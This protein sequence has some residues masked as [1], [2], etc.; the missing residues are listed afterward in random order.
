MP[1]P[2]NIVQMDPE[3]IAR[4]NEFVGKWAN[5]WLGDRYYHQAEIVQFVPAGKLPLKKYWVKVADKD[6]IVPIPRDYD[7]LLVRLKDG[8]YCY[9]PLDAHRE[10]GVI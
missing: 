10:V 7:S 3:A 2:D 8:T 9:P 1:E 5:F 6:S 4:R